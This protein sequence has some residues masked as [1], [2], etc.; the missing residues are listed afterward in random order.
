MYRSLYKPF[1]EKVNG[2][3]HRNTPWKIFFHSC[4]SIVDLLDDFVDVGVDIINPVQCS[5]RGMGAEGLKQRYGRRLVFW[6]AG[7][8]TQ[9]TLPFGTPQEVYDEVR[10]RVRIFNAGGG[11]VFNTIHNIQQNIPVDNMMALVRALRDSRT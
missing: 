5:A 11:F 1:H 4:G 7:V 10:Q 2:W 9:R 3:I 6:G 8:D